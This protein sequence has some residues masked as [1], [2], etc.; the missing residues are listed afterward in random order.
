MNQERT[1][2]WNAGSWT[3]RPAGTRQVG[4]NLQVTAS[5]G[6]DAWRETAYGFTFASENALLAPFPPDSAM[7]VEFTAQAFEQFDQAGIFLR[8][9]TDSWVKAGI[10]F[11][12]GR[13]Q[14]GA[15]VTAPKSDWSSSPHHEWLGKRTVVR[16]SWKGDALTIRAGLAGN[17]LELLRVAPFSPA[18]PVSAGP[19]V[20]S[21]SSARFEAVF[22]SWRVTA[23]DASLH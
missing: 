20:A 16:A 23:A 4:A 9:A 1:L 2:D 3:N 21:P 7:E 12:D 8:A 15:V 6:S 11:A 18:G 14:A 10:E 22:H 19:Y 5:E 17:P 13:L